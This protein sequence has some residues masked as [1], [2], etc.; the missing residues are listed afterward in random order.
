MGHVHGSLAWVNSSAVSEQCLSGNTATVV[1]PKLYNPETV[2][3]CTTMYN[4]KHYLKA[5]FV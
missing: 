5:T 1:V 2:Q 4:P 3:P